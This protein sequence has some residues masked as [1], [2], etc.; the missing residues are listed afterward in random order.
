M[1]LGSGAIMPC[2]P[3]P[4]RRTAA[5]ATAVFGTSL[6]ASVVILALSLPWSGAYGATTPPQAR[7]SQ[8]YEPAETPVPDP[9][10]E[11]PPTEPE[12]SSTSPPGSAPAPDPTEPPETS[13]AKSTKSKPQTA[14]KKS[15]DTAK[16]TP[17]ISGTAS[18]SGDRR[19][20]TP[21]QVTGVRPVE[22]P[23]VLPPDRVPEAGSLPRRDET[24]V[25]ADAV[26]EF[27]AAGDAI[28][29]PPRW[30]DQAF[31]VSLVAVG[32]IALTFSVSGIVVVALRRR[33]W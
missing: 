29:S 13:A 3:Q 22:P 21:A 1:D 8:G 30:P 12:S 17:G 9:T 18:R 28:P 6:V 23:G 27:A 10:D 5:G 16:K 33:R 14:D 31:G 7:V 24:A 4:V 2:V 26:A 25:G 20:G 15:T 11:G 19:A 32:L